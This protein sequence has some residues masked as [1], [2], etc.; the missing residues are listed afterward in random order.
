M[1]IAS[2]PPPGP[3][4]RARHVQQWLVLVDR[5][6][7]P[8]RTRFFERLP[9]TLKASIEAASPVSWVPVEQ[10]VALADLTRAAFGAQAAHHYYRRTLPESLKSPIFSTFVESG[11][12]VLG[13]DPGAFLRWMPRAWGLIFRNCGEVRGLVTSARRGVLEYR[14]LPAVCVASDAWLES[15]QGTASG[16]FDITGVEGV[17]RSDLSGRARGEMTIEL[18]WWP[19]TS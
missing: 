6:D 11:L 8:Y 4:V 12:R 15:A 5:Y 16:V 7:E 10:H 2:I 17:V 3:S 14:G 1:P 9:A 13:V 18:E 19:K